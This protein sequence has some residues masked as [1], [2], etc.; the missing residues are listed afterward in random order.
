MRL[1][2]STDSHQ[3]SRDS[4]TQPMS[5]QYIQEVI[6]NPTMPN[7]TIANFVA[8]VLCDLIQ[9]TVQNCVSNYLLVCTA[10]C[11]DGKIRLGPMGFEGCLNLIE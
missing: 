4:L 11:F 2:E 9:N 3:C 8:F 1:R 5:K 6:R 7:Q 10:S